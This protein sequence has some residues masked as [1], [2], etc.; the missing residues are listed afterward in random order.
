VGQNLK[1]IYPGNP[2]VIKHE[3]LTNLYYNHSGAYIAGRGFSIKEPSKTAVPTPT[4]DAK[5]KGLP[6]NGDLNYPLT[7]STTNPEVAHGFNLIGNPYPSNLDIE[8]LFDANVTLMEPTF[9]FWDNRGNIL[10]N[11]EGSNYNGDNFAK[12]NA[13][14]GT[15][16][17]TGQP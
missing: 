15:G 11:Q 8:A 5:F 9:L 13:V 10:Y 4:I 6:F 16:T 14:S 3:E 7:Y 2:T 12:Y 17:G 1:T